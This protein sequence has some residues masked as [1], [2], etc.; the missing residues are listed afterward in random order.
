MNYISA[1]Q[2]A[3]R[4]SLTPRRVQELCKEGRVLGAVR[5]GRNWMIPAEAPKPM[6]RKSAEPAETTTQQ[7]LRNCPSLD[8]TD[9]Y[10]EPGSA[11]S[12]IQSLSP[13]PETALLLA[14]CIAYQRCE[15]DLVLQ[16]VS[17]LKNTYS[18]IHSAIL[19]GLL[20]C[21][22][23]AYM[24]DTALYRQARKELHQTPCRNGEE[25]EI[26]RLWLSFADATVQDTLSYPEW[27]T[28]G[29]FYHVPADSF[30]AVTF[31][32]ARYLY[33]RAQ[34]LAMGNTRFGHMKGLDL[35]RTL[36]GIFEPM[37]AQATKEGTLIVEIGLR[38]LC[39]VVYHNL[40][41]DE[42]SI[43]HID[44]AIQ[45]AL[46]DRLF[47][48]LV[49]YRMALAPLFDERMA[50]ADPD[51][52]REIRQLYRDTMEGWVVLHNANN[53]RS[54]SNLLSPRERETARLAAFGLS[55][56][57]IA[58]RLGISLASV[59]TYLSMAMNKT[60]AENRFELGVY[61]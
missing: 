22:I 3:E 59:K 8:M 15:F 32:Y 4:W 52:L 31:H 29:K 20:R 57:E 43:M 51:A 26:L 27:F 36:P 34:S 14:T 13:Y 56:K 38:L 61:L 45:L 21:L 55:N 7:L 46:P 6:R 49:E 30:P 18:D 60:G 2:A 1:Q 44:R 5:F 23:A 50:I 33:F 11:D 48:M 10:R 58:A 24:G 41:E 17:L 28:K 37:I 40:G 16:N 42:D 53:D 35:L 19:A 25:R 9:L 54:I 12:L 47:I 39:A